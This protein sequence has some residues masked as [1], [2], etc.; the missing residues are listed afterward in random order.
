MQEQWEHME[1]KTTRELCEHFHIGPRTARAYIRMTPDEIQKLDSPARYK[2]R[3]RIGDKFV[4]IIYKM[5]RDG[6][7]D[8]V[9]FYYI[10]Q[11]GIAIT[12]NTLWSYIRSISVNNFP[13]RPRYYALKQKDLHYPDDVTVIRRNDLLKYLLTVNPKTEKD[14][15]I[16]MYVE[17]ILQKYPIAAWVMEAFQSFHSI[18]MGD[19]V[20]RLD[21]FIAQYSD[22]K[23]KSFCDGLKKDIAPVK[24]AISLEV[25]SGFVEGN[26]NKFKLLKRVVYGRS[27]LV[28][29][30]KKCKLAFMPDTD[31]FRL[32]SLI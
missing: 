9:I 25:S 8:E 20:S 26:N 10:K 2:R 16:G 5:M 7:T 14:E 32:D 29:L 12:D 23:I 17:K 19:E 22:T 15:K 31:D 13:A 11:K 6:K 27:G 18:L 3:K 4:N 28:N 30:E 1:T 21:E 24:N